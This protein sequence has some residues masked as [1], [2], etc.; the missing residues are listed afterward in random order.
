M[1]RLVVTYPAPDDPHAFVAYYERAHLPRARLMPGMLD[2]RFGYPKPVTPGAGQPF[3]IFEADFTSEASLL[4]ALNSDQGKVAA[5]DIA[6][7]SPQGCAISFYEVR[8]PH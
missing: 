2:A 7:F 1:H 8:L 4:A 6:N 3:C 5:R